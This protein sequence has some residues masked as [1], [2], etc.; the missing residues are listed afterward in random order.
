MSSYQDAS[1][2]RRLWSLAKPGDPIAEYVSNV[3]VVNDRRFSSSRE[4]APYAWHSVLMGAAGAGI[5]NFLELQGLDA[6][7]PTVNLLHR[8]RGETAMANTL[9][10]LITVAIAD[11]AALTTA[12][13]VLTTPLVSDA[14][15][16]VTPRLFLGTIA[17]ANIPAVSAV[18]PRSNA[19]GQTGATPTFSQAVSELEPTEALPFAVSWEGPASLMFFSGADEL[20]IFEAVWQAMRA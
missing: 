12:T 1:W 5:H 14:D 15:P 2:I 18:L 16:D 19:I 6:L 17:S 20:C 13:R 4:R 11:G 9:T 10:G 3:S 8:F 7:G